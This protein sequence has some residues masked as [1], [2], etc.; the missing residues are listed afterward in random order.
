MYFGIKSPINKSR[1]QQDLRF[2]WMP[3]ILTKEQRSPTF[4]AS[5]YENHIMV[6]G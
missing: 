6:F 5:N 3:D 4:C 1:E 2:V